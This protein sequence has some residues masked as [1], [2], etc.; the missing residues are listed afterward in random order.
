MPLPVERQGPRRFC[1]WS[2]PPSYTFLR[3]EAGQQLFLPL[4]SCRNKRSERVTE[5]LSPG[6]YWKTD[7]NLGVFDPKP[8]G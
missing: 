4:S 2:L 8:V 7:S 6:Q 5:V 3:R 1:M